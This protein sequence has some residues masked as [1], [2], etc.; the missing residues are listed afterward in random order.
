M[1]QPTIADKK[2]TKYGGIKG[3]ISMDADN[4]ESGTT[5]YVRAY[6]IQEG[7]PVYGETVVFTTAELPSVVTL[8]PTEMEP[9]DM[10]GGLYLYYSARFNGNVT[11]SGDPSYTSKGFAYG[12]TRDPSATADNSV[13]VSGRGEGKYSAVVSNLTA[14]RTY[15]VR[16]WVKAESGYVYGESIQFSTF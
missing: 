3:R 4:L 16:A 15:Y 11:S 10:G 6:A 12:T 8:S 7:Q 9:V 1:K 2:V 5:Y 13:T 14:N